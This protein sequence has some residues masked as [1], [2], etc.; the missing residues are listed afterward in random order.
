VG[1][2]TIGTVHCYVAAS[3]P[4]VVAETRP[5]AE[6]LAAYRSIRHRL[7]GPAAHPSGYASIEV[8][9]NAYLHAFEGQVLDTAH[10]V[11]RRQLSRVSQEL[12]DNFFGHIHTLGTAEV[13]RPLN[14]G[15]DD[16]GVGDA[17]RFGQQHRLLEAAGVADHDVV[18]K[19]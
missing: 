1:C 13:I 4:P 18:P 15:V 5:T 14:D 7:L 3:Q 8:A 12:R 17:P 11:L 10:A 16:D 9:A 6:A 2:A 19:G